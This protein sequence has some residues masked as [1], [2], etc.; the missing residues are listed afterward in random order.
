M[1]LKDIMD[2]KASEKFWTG[3]KNF[4]NFKSRKKLIKIKFKKKT[5]N[6]PK[7]DLDNRP[8]YINYPIPTACNFDENISEED[9]YI[10][11]IYTTQFQLPNICLS[12][13]PS[14]YSFLNQLRYF[15]NKILLH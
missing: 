5:N 14:S 7:S 4:S 6:K 13:Y 3:D 11:Q 2:A 1:T 9:I 15:I 8:F 10:K 12:S